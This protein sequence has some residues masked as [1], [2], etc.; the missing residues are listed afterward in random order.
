MPATEGL[1]RSKPEKLLAHLI[2]HESD[3]SILA[4][5]KKRMWANELSSYMYR[6]SHDFG[7]FGVEIKLTEEGL[8]HVQDVI[9]AVF[10]YI[11]LLQR[12]GIDDWVWDE[13]KDTGAMKF[14]FKDKSEPSDDA[15]SLAT[16]MAVMAPTEVLAGHDLFFE[17]NLEKTRE[18]LANVNPDN[19]LVFLVHKGAAEKADK[20]ERWYTTPYAE[21]AFTTEERAHWQRVLSGDD[22]DNLWS[23]DLHLPQPNP[24]VPTDFT[25][26][27]SD[28][29]TEAKL[30]LLVGHE[31]NPGALRQYFA[32]AVATA[33]VTGDASAPASAVTE[34][35]PEA[36]GEKEGEEADGEEG[37]EG[38]EDEENEDDEAGPVSAANKPSYVTWNEVLSGNQLVLWH[39]LDAHWNT[40]KAVVQFNLES[41]FAFS[42]PWNVVLTDLLSRILTELLNEF[43]YYADCAGLH[44]YVSVAKSGL[45]FR[46]DGYN[47]KLPVLVT[48]A[49]EELRR[50]ADSSSSSDSSATTYNPAL[51][52]RVKEA[53]SRA[54]KNQLFQQSYYHAMLGAYECLEEP[55]FGLFEKIQ[56]LPHIQLDSLQA[57]A[58][59][60]LSQLSLEVFVNGNISVD[61][62]KQLAIAAKNTLQ[63]THLPYSLQAIRRPVQ[64]PT[65]RHFVYRQTGQTYNPEELN[66]ASF[67]MFM[68][69]EEPG[70]ASV[71]DV[72]GAST[73]E[74]GLILQN[75]RNLFV[76]MMSEPAFDQLR[77]K[78]QLGYVVHLTGRELA[79]RLLTVTVIVQSNV[80]DPVYLDGRI[81]AFLRQYRDEVLATMDETTLQTFINAEIE[82]LLEKPKNLDQETRWFSAE[83]TKGTYLFDRGQRLVALLRREGLYSVQKM[84]EMFDKYFGLQSAARTSFSSQLF[85]KNRRVPTKAEALA[86]FDAEG[87]TNVT[88]VEDIMEFKRRLPLL[89]LPS[90][91]PKPF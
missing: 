42:S 46:F 59:Q 77:T 63:A 14:R 9:A 74:E 67:V 75:Y 87:R 5:L 60:F 31:G 54:Y 20:R 73:L 1:Y 69:G 64:L 23:K 80:Q 85:G 51:F 89:P 16:T 81:E 68:F 49:M 53:I 48:R 43:A 6:S 19:A 26:K 56:T 15:V 82:S 33:A 90:H 84:Q 50:F 17:K 47:H 44:Y 37:E 10:A 4:A 78:E 58:R 29:A 3:G 39:R 57:F 34:S 28:V 18:L 27:G 71:D 91:L 13:L 40:P 79:D 66:S 88:I 72:S 70:I 11:G 76:R 45:T 35:D 30:P 24:F 21:R 22:D 41:Q 32:S 55:R 38:E 52:A 7:V 8:V 25:I 61:E 65:G 86:A 12:Q 2:G 62:A 36:E 83:L